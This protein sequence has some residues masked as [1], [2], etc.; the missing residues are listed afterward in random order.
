MDE[1][2]VHQ[3]GWLVLADKRL[4]QRDELFVLMDQGFYVK[5]VLLVFTEE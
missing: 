2:S 5:D 4:V 1:L 3:D